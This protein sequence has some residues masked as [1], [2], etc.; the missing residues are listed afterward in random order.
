MVDAATVGAGT[1][2]QGTCCSA[3]GRMR[4]SDGTSSVTPAG[5]GRSEPA[6]SLQQQKVEKKGKGEKVEMREKGEWK[7]QLQFCQD[8]A[9]IFI[10]KHNVGTR[11]M[12]KK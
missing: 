8:Q 11:K 2:M 6:P 12:I 9:L 3:R 7:R 10:S 5:S 1:I 4:D